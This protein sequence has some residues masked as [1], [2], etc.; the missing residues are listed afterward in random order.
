MGQVLLSPGDELSS[1]TPG[2]NWQSGIFKF[3]GRS[4]TSEPR[5][6][7]GFALSVGIVEPWGEAHGQRDGRDPFWKARTK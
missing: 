4:E 5:Y 2:A 7:H 1:E 6:G 3:H